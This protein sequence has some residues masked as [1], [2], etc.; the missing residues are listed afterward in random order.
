MRRALGGFCASDAQN[1]L[2]TPSS[3]TLCQW[4][5]TMKHNKSAVE[6][7]TV[8]SSFWVVEPQLDRSYIVLCC[9]VVILF[10]GAWFWVWSIGVSRPAV[11]I[12]TAFGLLISLLWCRIRILR[13]DLRTWQW[14]TATKQPRYGRTAGVII[15]LASAAG[16]LTAHAIIQITGQDFQ[17]GLMA[18]IYICCGVF[19]LWGLLEGIRHLWYHRHRT[20]DR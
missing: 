6:P 19:G 10:T 13:F 8:E 2:I 17:L 20:S 7:N 18:A 9:S 14:R 11:V 3:R 16:T 1:W 5:A 4:T 15:G 12:G